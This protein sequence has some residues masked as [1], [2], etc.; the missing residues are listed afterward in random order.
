ML[1]STSVLIVVISNNVDKSSWI[2]WEINYATG[3]QTRNGRQ[4]QPNGVVMAIE[5]HLIFNENKY[6][7]HQTTKL[8]SE[9]SSPVVVKL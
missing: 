7:P 6:T 3:R 8:I 5:D 1:F 2:K 9:K 4:S